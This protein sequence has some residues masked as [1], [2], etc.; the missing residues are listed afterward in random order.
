RE[1]N[2]KNS[3]AEIERKLESILER[4]R[5]TLEALRE[6]KPGMEEKQRELA[7]LPRKLSEALRRLENYEFEDG[8]AQADFDELL[9]EYENI[10]DL[11]N[12]RDRH[13]QAF[14]GP[15]SLGYREAVDMMREMERMRNLEQALM[16]GDLDQVSGEEL[17][18]MLGGQAQEDFENL[19]QAMMLLDESG[20]LLTRG[21]HT[22]LSPKGVRRIGQL[23]LRDI[24]QGML[25]DRGGGHT[26]DH[27]GATQIRPDVTKPYVYGDPMNLN[28]VETLKHALA[29]KPGVPLALGPEDF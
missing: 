23:A 12:F 28:L 21:D 22:S 11:E 5:R 16:A 19:K 20:Y 10:R 17:N 2:L 15:K 13:G 14:R 3:L 9:K 29:R 25:R 24:F 8:E 6:R 7:H 27:R 18:A 1:F 4:E 26:M